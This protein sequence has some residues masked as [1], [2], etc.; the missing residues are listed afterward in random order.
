M[1]IHSWL[2]LFVVIP[3]L[4]AFQALILA[5]GG[6]EPDGSTPATPTADT[7]ETEGLSSS[8][9]GLR[10]TEIPATSANGPLSTEQPA[11]SAR[12]GQPTEE[13]G[14]SEGDGG[15]A[16]R[17]PATEAPAATGEISATKMVG[18]TGDADTPER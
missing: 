12:G 3:L 7:L 10:P 4:M 6:E 5:C 9:T 14:T 17:A 2:P 15:D 8:A 1:K 11:M 16:R 13:A 18:G